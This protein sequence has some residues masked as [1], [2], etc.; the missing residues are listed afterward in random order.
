MSL[1]NWRWRLSAVVDPVRIAGL[2][3]AIIANQRQVSSES[4]SGWL[5]LCAGDAAGAVGEVRSPEGDAGVVAF[6]ADTGWRYAA[7]GPRRAG[8]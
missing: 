5:L 2:A 8:C 4:R 6:S 1:S 7:Y 3:V